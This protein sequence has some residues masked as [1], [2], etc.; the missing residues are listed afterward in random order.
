[1]NKIIFDITRRAHPDTL[2][3]ATATAKEEALD[4]YDLGVDYVIMPHLL[5][6]Q[7]AASLFEEHM[8][9]RD[10]YDMIRHH[11]LNELRSHNVI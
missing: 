5:G 1:M 9:K 7:H 6:S 8:F 2:F 3:V 11:H 10:G 4:L